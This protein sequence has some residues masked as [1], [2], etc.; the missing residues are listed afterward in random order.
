MSFGKFN[1]NNNKKKNKKPKS[2]PSAGKNSEQTLLQ[3]SEFENDDKT[4]T[5]AEF[6][7][8]KPIKPSLAKKPASSN[9]INSNSNIIL[10][11]DDNL[12]DAGNNNQ[13]K[14]EKQKKLPPS[15]YINTDDFDL[16]LSD[17]D[18]DYGQEEQKDTTLKPSSSIS[19][20]EPKVTFSKIKEK[21]SK[22]SSIIPNKQDKTAKQTPPKIQPSNNEIN[23]QKTKSQGK[24]GY[25]GMKPKVKAGSEMVMQ[26][27][28]S[29]SR[30][31]DLVSNNMQLNADITNIGK[32]SMNNSFYYNDEKMI[33]INALLS[34]M[35]R[36][37]KS[38]PYYIFASSVATACSKNETYFIRNSAQE[39]IKI[40]TSN[41][42]SAISS[43][44]LDKSFEQQLGVLRSINFILSSLNPGVR[45]S[46]A[47]TRRR[48]SESI[49][50]DTPQPYSDE[51]PSLQTGEIISE[52]EQLL[53]ENLAK[54]R[55][56]QS[57]ID[58][59]KNIIIKGNVFLSLEFYLSQ[60][61]ISLVNTVITNVQLLPDDNDNISDRRYNPNKIIELKP[62][63]RNKLAE[64]CAL[65][66]STY[67]MLNASR[68]TTKF[69]HV[70]SKNIYNEN[71]LL[72]KKMLEEDNDVLD[73]DYIRPALN[74][75]NRFDYSSP[76]FDISPSPSPSPFS[77]YIPPIQPQQTETERILTMPPVQEYTPTTPPQDIFSPFS[78]SVFMRSE[79]KKKKRL[80]S[81]KKY[82]TVPKRFR[83]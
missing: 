3:F 50:L 42:K 64:L 23:N 49:I 7:T 34:E 19:A 58:T 53:R 37:I 46:G 61:L 80:A 79:G 24:K 78:P 81:S 44:G 33:Q 15:T 6:L 56:L 18:I 60:D 47:S 32:N 5:D 1:N 27:F 51:L 41:G 40:I 12:M 14:T 70:S 38:N 72:L 77:P 66:Y 25:S 65:T 57:E 75:M 39:L 73:D 63:I 69:L 74:Q 20:S 13:I 8:K 54:I 45:L 71:M 83:I 48:G 59:I 35:I 28:G 29:S 17:N 67:G 2:K 4:T 30:S 21:Q 9:N 76:Y 11:F 82:Y 55:I 31:V 62:M 10:D 43:S 68:P 22:S 26:S 52:A 36:F 16:S